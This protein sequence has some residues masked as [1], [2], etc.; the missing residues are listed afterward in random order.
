M[1]EVN[2]EYI[3]VY[4][5]LYYLVFTLIDIKQFLLHLVLLFNE[6]ACRSFTHASQNFS[7]IPLISILVDYFNFTKLHRSD[8]LLT[9]HFY[10]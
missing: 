6:F 8:T 9:L 5:F 4:Y 2:E 1:S 7:Y 3:F 10:T